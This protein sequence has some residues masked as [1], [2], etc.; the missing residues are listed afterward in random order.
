M[1]S[2]VIINNYFWCFY[3]FL[4]TKWLSLLT[5]TVVQLL[6]CVWLFPTPWTTAYQASLSFTISRVYSDSHPLSQWCHPTMPYQSISPPSPPP[7]L[8]LSQNQ[9]LFQWISSSA[10]SGKSIGVS[11]SASLLPVNIQGWFPWGL[12]GLIS[13]QCKGLSRVFSSTTIWK[14][15]FFSSQPSLWVFQ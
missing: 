10:W 8:N 2:V 15:Q 3:G 12:T 11:A 9:G 1:T 5:F 14:H 7:A 4:S 6:S 13:L